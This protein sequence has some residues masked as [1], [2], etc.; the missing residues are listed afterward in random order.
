[1]SKGD[2]CTVTGCPRKQ[3]A[4]GVCAKHYAE[5][6]RLWTKGVV[7]R[8]NATHQ[9]LK[10]RHGPASNYGCVDCE[11]QAEQWSYNGGDPDEL[12]ETIRGTLVP[13][14]LKDDY[15][16]SRCIRC[17]RIHDKRHLR[18]APAAKLTEEQV[19]EIFHAT[20]TQAEIARAFGVSAQ[21][22]SR[23]KSKTSWRYI[24]KDL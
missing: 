23:I 18:R 9:R 20:G 6:P 7:S 22:V 10:E 15:Y 8:Y 16:S 1:M 2:P 4:R 5:L 14:S 21:A 24:T 12:L 19:I 11:R 17:H 13:Y 3:L